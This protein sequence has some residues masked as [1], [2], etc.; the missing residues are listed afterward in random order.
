MES[1]IKNETS[2]TAGD[3]RNVSSDEV[4]TAVVLLPSDPFE[5]YRGFSFRFVFTLVGCLIILSNVT[6]IGSLVSSR[7]L[8]FSGFYPV[9][10]LAIADSLVGFHILQFSVFHLPENPTIQFCLVLM[11][12]GTTCI[13]AS[14][15]NILLIAV[16]RYIYVRYGIHYY[17]WMTK[18]MTIAIIILSWATSIIFGYAPVYGWWSGVFNNRCSVREMLAKEYLLLLAIA[19]FLAPFAIITVLYF[20]IFFSAYTKRIQDMDQINRLHSSKEQDP[21][22][23]FHKRSERIRMIRR[24]RSWKIVVVVFLAFLFTWMPYLFFIIIF[25]TSKEESSPSTPSEKK[26]YD[27]LAL[28]GY[29]HSGFNPCI[30]FYWQKTF[31]KNVEKIICCNKQRIH[32][33]SSN[34]KTLV[35]HIDSIP[36]F[37]P[38]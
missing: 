10:S 19:F 16:D 31:I 23:K 2:A 25:N 11:S 17:I 3:I 7:R 15:L 21:T 37:S 26:A 1:D 33:D 12:T 30:Y 34:T 38:Y 8:R 24:M 22:A 4:A 28:F 20:N 5:T 32:P 18:K 35:F 29:L 6:V 13:L 36:I 27:V 14:V 9:V